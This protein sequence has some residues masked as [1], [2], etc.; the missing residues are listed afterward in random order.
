MIRNPVVAGVF[1]PADSNEL[2][3]L[4]EYCYL[5]KLGPKEIPSE[6]GIFKKPVGLICPHAGYIYSG[7][8]AAHSYNALSKRADI[9]DE[10]T[11][12]IIGPN[13]T[14]LG[15]GV[16]TMKGIWKTPLGNLEIDNEFVDRLWKECDIMDLDETSHLHEHSIEVQ[17]PFLQHLSILNIAKFKFVPISMLFQD[18]ETS[19]DVGYF[20]AKIA[21]E[22]NRRVVVIASTDF[23][24][25]EPQEVAAKKDAIAI[26][27]ILNMDEE[28]LYSDVVNYNISMCGCGPV[29]AMIKAMKLL[30]GKEAKLL[31]YATSGDITKDYSSVVG[32]A[33]IIIE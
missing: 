7:P 14:G 8:I 11:A 6:G 21:K 15:T 1:Y 9:E 10:I 33:S 26:K 28:E 13:H 30:G 31:S 27:N 19:V 22:L 16:A 4:I 5:H 29:M 12:V 32:Y 2:I 17:L 25:Y 24:H 3:E 23:T 18:Y 20:I